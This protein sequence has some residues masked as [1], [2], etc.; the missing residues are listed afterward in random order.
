MLRT[1]VFGSGVRNPTW[2]RPQPAKCSRLR[3]WTLL[4]P[5]VPKGRTSGAQTTFTRSWF[6]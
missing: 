5:S 2:A 3:A 4:V 6:P 1:V